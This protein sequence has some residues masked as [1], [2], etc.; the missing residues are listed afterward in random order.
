MYIVENGDY[1]SHIG[2]LIEVKHG[3]LV[4]G[5][6]SEWHPAIFGSSAYIKFS[7][8]ISAVLS[9]GEQME[10]QV[11]WFDYDTRDRAGFYVSMQR[12]FNCLAHLKTDTEFTK[13]AEYIKQRYADKT[14]TM[15]IRPDA[16]AEIFMEL[17]GKDDSD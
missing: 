2:C 7:G 3:I 14:G 9:N 16:V 13:L 10:P 8:I 4:K 11:H 6:L 1:E 15:L 17:M 5:Y 12:P